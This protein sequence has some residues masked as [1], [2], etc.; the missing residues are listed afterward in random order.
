MLGSPAGSQRWRHGRVSYRPPGE[1]I[2]PH[3]YEVA[4]IDDDT[5]AREFVV[6]H[7]YSHAYVAARRR[8]GL[9]WHGKLAGVAVFSHP[10]NDRVLTNVFPGQARD[11]FELGRLILVDAVP[12]NGESWFV[13]RAFDCLRRDGYVGVVSFSD[14]VARVSVDGS[15]VHPGHIGVVY[16]AL[17]A[18]YLGRG[19]PRVLRLLPDGTVFSDRAAQKIRAE[20]RGWRSCA[21]VLER[22][23]AEPPAGDLRDWLKRWLGRL[24]RPLRHPGNHRYAWPLHRE[25]RRFLL[26]SLPY[27]RRS[28]SEQQAPTA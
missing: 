21:A 7:H 3:E 13:A 1:V 19:T 10:C 27:P 22:F 17:S 5:T 4:E 12:T 23:G 16:M 8:F 25:A 24:T 9:Y 26:P 15:I 20:E 14:P 11:S 6:L 2:R 28:A 18:R